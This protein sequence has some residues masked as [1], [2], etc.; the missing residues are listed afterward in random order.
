VAR[1]EMSMPKSQPNHANTKIP[2]C[3]ILVVTGKGGVGKTAIATALAAQSAKEGKRTLLTIYEREDTRHPL[4]GTKVTY[5][6]NQAAPNLWVSRLD[7]RLS[8][9]EYVHRTI[10]LHL[11]Y[12]WVLDGKILG[13]FTDA[14]PGFDELMCL[15]KLYDLAEGSNGKAHFDR[16]IFDAPA[17]GHCAL[18]LRT[19]KVTAETVRTGPLYQSALS[20]HDMLAD[21]K[22]CSVLVVSLAE[23]MALQEGTELCQYVSDE[24]N[25]NA[26]PM[27]V[28]RVRP[29]R[30][31]VDEIEHLR[32]LQ[33]SS[34]QS[35]A[36]IDSA[37]AHYKLSALQENYTRALRETMPD[38]IEVPQ[39]I[40][41]AFRPSELVEAMAA[42]LAPSLQQGTEK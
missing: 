13:Q 34:P 37:I 6:L 28:N 10:P 39:M 15:G 25:F 38:V 9:K 8:M 7:A 30:Y 4:L 14:A 21:K 17:T 23:E 36:V 26:G 31:D 16:I 32:S 11:L 42:S 20:V 40:Q 41:N 35:Q 27:I 3:Q 22:R 24:L 5:G 33:G 2:P 29:Q 18:M 19:P 1:N 12:D